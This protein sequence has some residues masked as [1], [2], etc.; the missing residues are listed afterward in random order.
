MIPVMPG[1]FSQAYRVGL[2]TVT[3][4]S[5]FFKIP[6]LPN[7]YFILLPKAVDPK[8]FFESLPFLDFL[9]Y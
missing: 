5:G 2:D 8:L 9:K 7:V 3:Y 1:L 6:T 4:C